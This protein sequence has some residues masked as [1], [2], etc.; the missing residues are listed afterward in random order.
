MTTQT[1]GTGATANS[2]VPVTVDTFVRAETDTYF[3]AI[4]RDAGALATFNHNRELFDI[5]AQTVVRLNRDTLYSSALVDLEVGPVTITL[6]DTGDR[7]M[8]LLVINE[9]HYAFAVYAPGTFTFGADDLGA[10]YATFAIRTFIDPEDPD[11]LSRVNALQ[12]AITIAQPGGP[13][14]FTV[15]TWDATSQKTVR[16][17]LLVLN[18]TLP[19]MRHAFGR[20]EDIDPV[21]HLIGA[22]SAWGGNPDQDALYLNVTPTQNDGTTPYRITVPAE[23]P[24]DGFWS[25]TVYNAEGYMEPNALGAYSLNSLSAQPNADGTVTVQFG[26]CDD[27]IPNCLPTP[28]QWN[29][30]VRL[31]RPRPE[32]LAGTWTFPMAQLAE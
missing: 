23:V 10:R 7:F 16:D 1:P 28:A 4:L 32:L 22:A 5:N 19:D 6:P 11:D 8:S 30:M 18:S 21:R 13:G 14:S 12:D 15:P 26:G 24:V 17:A 25:I 31:Y 3:A 2:P 9:D 29:Y 27:A 20:Q